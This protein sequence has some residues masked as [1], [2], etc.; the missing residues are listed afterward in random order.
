MTTEREPSMRDFQVLVEFLP[1][2]YGGRAPPPVVRWITETEDGALTLP[3]PE[4]NETVRSFID[5]I[6]NQGCWMVGS[7]NPEEVEKLLVDEEA[8]KDAMLPEI[9]RMFTLVVRGERFCSGWPSSMIED[10]HVRRLLE[11]LAEIGAEC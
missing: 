5:L 10:G 4:Y 8:V 11:R 7:Y 1:K 2:L 9:R 3:W 6:E